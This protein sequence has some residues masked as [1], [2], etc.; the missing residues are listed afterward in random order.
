MTDKVNEERMRV[1][2]NSAKSRQVNESKKLLMMI[3]IKSSEKEKRQ[4]IVSETVK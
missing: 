2:I 1:R 3:I 4:S